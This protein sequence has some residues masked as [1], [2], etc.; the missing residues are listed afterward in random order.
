MGR[1]LAKCL[2]VALL[3]SLTACSSQDKELDNTE[4]SDAVSAAVEESEYVGPIYGQTEPL[5]PCSE[6]ISTSS[7][8]EGKRFMI[9]SEI[10]D[11]YANASRDS[12]R[13]RV[14]SL[15]LSYD[16]SGE[17]PVLVKGVP[18]SSLTSDGIGKRRLQ[19]MSFR[20]ECTYDGVD[21]IGTSARIDEENDIL[22]GPS[23]TYEFGY[24]VSN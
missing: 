14:A 8:Y 21:I 10:L 18:A 20:V 3:V 11:A 22:I 7:P 1:L 2:F 17:A 9:E 13:Y 12:G 24:L 15:L 4:A 6:L 23:F 19:G 16:G 5:P